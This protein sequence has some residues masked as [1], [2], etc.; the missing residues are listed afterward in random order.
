MTLSKLGLSAFVASAATFTYS[1]APVPTVFHHELATSS[2]SSS[3][4]NTVLYISSWGKV[5]LDA[6]MDFGVATTYNPDANIQSYLQEPDELDP[7]DHL[8]GTV[9][10]SGLVNTKER[11]DQFIFDLLNHE[12]SAFEYDKIV[13]FV[14]DAK[15]SK[16][17]LLSRSARY[18][19]LL[20]KLDF[21][22]ASSEG[23]LPTIDQLE[24]INSW[25]AT[26]ESNNDLIDQV[27]TIAMLAKDAPSLENISVMVTNAAGD[28]TSAEDRATAVEALKDTGKEYTLL[29]IGTLEDHDDGKIPYRITNFTSGNDVLI[30]ENSV[31]SRDEAMRMFTETLQLDSGAGKDLTFLEVYDNNATEAKL[32]KGLREAGYARPQE[33]DHMLRNGTANYQKA[34]DDFREKNPNWD[35]TKLKPGSKLIEPWWEEPEFLAEIAKEEASYKRG[36]DD[37]EEEEEKSPR[38]LEIEKIA[39]EWAKRE[40]FSQSMAETVEEDMTEEAYI[41]SVWERALFEGDLKF[42]QINGED[43]D[44]EVELL[45]FK[46]QQER[47][48]QTMLK[49]AKKELQEVL[50]EENISLD[51]SED[52]IDDDEE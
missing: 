34:L 36:T 13:A 18:T 11:S 17:R 19:G 15:F 50:D 28:V 46:K 40:Y 10:V 41:E 37:E 29:V 51:D 21:R 49:K 22:E 27:K 6:D 14:N 47:K 39:T 52:E 7:R 33:I 8:E 9:M 3:S 12:E 43:A 32:I 30:P 5:G 45:D 1:F 38:T 16:K 48:Q 25:L 4:S 31:F 2:S 42:R 23:S 20:D 35:K 24:G 26:V 44:V